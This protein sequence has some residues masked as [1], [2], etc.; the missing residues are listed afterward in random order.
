MSYT[1]NQITIPWVGAPTLEEMMPLSSCTRGQDPSDSIPKWL[2]YSDPFTGFPYGGMV[3]QTFEILIPRH[4]LI[5]VEDR[6]WLE[7]TLRQNNQ[8]PISQKHLDKIRGLWTYA[9]TKCTDQR[10][11]NKEHLLDLGRHYIESLETAVSIDRTS[12]GWLPHLKVDDLRK[13]L[14]N[15]QEEIVRAHAWYARVEV[16]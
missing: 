3:L 4:Y 11:Y 15:H 12:K 9:V 16:M 10:K 6:N 8:K 5:G 14:A 2:S 7:M 1:A 13:T